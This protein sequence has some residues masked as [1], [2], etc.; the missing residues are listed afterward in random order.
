M[1]SR[2]VKNTKIADG[3]KK[4]PSKPG[5]YLFKDSEGHILY[6]GKAKNLKKRGA[7]YLR[8]VGRDIKVDGLFAES[9]H[10]DYQETKGELEAPLL[11][12]QLI[13]SNQPKFNVLLKT[14]QPFI[15]LF[16]SSGTVPELKMVRNR[17]QKGSYFGPF[18]DKGAAR[19]VY[20]FLVKTFRL[21]LCKK[22]IEHGCLDYHLGICAGQCR[23]DFD[24]DAYQDRIALARRAMAQ[25]HREFL[26]DLMQQ[27]KVCSERQ[28]F[29]RA[30]ELLGYY[31]ACQK[32][33]AYL[34]VKP[35]SVGGRIGHDIWILADD[36]KSLHVLLEQQ[37]VLK[38]KQSFYFP[39]GDE[40]GVEDY[41]IGYYRTYRPAI[42]ILT[43]FKLTSAARTL[44]QKFLTQWHQLEQAVTIMQPT[45][46]HEASLIKY[47][48]AQVAQVLDKKAT[49]GVS[50][51]RLL[52]LTKEP[53]TIDCFDI[54]H[55]QGLYKVG[56]CVRFT[57]GQPD[58]K[59]FRHFHIKTVKG[60]D[61]YA[62]LAEIVERRYRDGL[63]LPDLVVI[64]GGKGQLSAVR[65]LVPKGVAVASLAKREETIFSDRLPDGC[66]L[67]QASFVGQMLIALRDYAHHF[68]ISFHRKV[69]RE[70]LDKGV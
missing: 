23:P 53:R 24:K 39:F 57:E 4:L 63:D 38:V 48:T 18:L 7:S 65:A 51:K 16:F 8:G 52:K 12:A 28:E 29:E 1:I 31:Q 17:K 37:N 33:F 13:Q 58:K 10:I 6:I 50:L 40:G 11:E 64:D 15:Y 47:A 14:G 67:D 68:A 55:K 61:D 69:A 46:G 59:M 21:K 56:S 43:N 22:K 2:D 26:H 42:R 36:G 5:V 20:D 62:S 9:D 60:Q 32:V 66:K 70:S 25:G 41:F 54:S 44:Y 19:R 35:M 49:L 34:D 30:Q 27:V 3:I 45:V